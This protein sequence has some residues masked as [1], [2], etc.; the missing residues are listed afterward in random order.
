MSY[1]RDNVGDCFS[2]MKKHIEETNS[3]N[4][5]EHTYTNVRKAL[6]NVRKTCLKK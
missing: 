2:A 1:K 6:K 4:V 3:T 5:R